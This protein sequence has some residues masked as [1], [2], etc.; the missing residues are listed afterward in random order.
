[1][2]KNKI[3]GYSYS[4]IDKRINEAYE[5]FVKDIYRNNKVSKLDV[6]CLVSKKLLRFAIKE[7]CKNIVNK[8]G[9]KGIRLR[10]KINQTNELF[11][12]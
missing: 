5:F 10:R 1:M 3:S 12:I 6:A 11:N 2:K 7:Y 9:L 4:N 8:Y